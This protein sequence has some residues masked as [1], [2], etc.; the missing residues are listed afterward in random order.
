VLVIVSDSSVL[1]DLAKVRLIESALA[2][3]Y[4]FVVPDV[5]FADELLDLGSYTR[6]DLLENGLQVGGLDGD[7]VVAAFGYA[8]RYLALSNNDA[9]ALALAK[10]G[11]GVLLAGDGA[12]RQ[13]AAEENVEVHGHLWLSDEMEKHKTVTRKRLLAVLEAWEDDPLVWLPSAELKAR[14]RRLQRKRK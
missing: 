10:T 4:Q 1:I 3:P 8:E 6:D 14:I 12:L 11:G 7:G 9:F 5:M 2:L 13:A